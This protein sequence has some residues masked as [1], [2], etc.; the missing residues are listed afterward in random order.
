[1]R[2]DFTRSV[3]FDLCAV[4]TDAFDGEGG[5]WNIRTR[6][7]LRSCK[8]CQTWNLRGLTGG[9]YAGERCQ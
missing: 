7:T 6:K 8:G 1:M 3:V 9:G 5:A 4:K 2:D